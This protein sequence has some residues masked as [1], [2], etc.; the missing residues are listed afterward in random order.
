MLVTGFRRR[1]TIPSVRPARFVRLGRRHTT[2][3]ERSC[4]RINTR[5]F[6]VSFVSRKL[7]ICK[8][9]AINAAINANYQ[10]GISM[11]Y[12]STPGV[13]PGGNCCTISSGH[14]TKCTITN[15]FASIDSRCGC[16]TNSCVLPINYGIVFIRGDTVGRAMFTISN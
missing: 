8:N 6:R 13:F 16:P 2:C 12:V 1:I 7:A 11:G 3:C 10:V 15:F 9:T 14:R 4:C 5:G